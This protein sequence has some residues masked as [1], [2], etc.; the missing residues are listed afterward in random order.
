MYIPSAEAMR[1]A[2]TAAGLAG[3]GAAV[4]AGAGAGL[5]GAATGSSTHTEAAD[6]VSTGDPVCTKL[7]DDEMSTATHK[8]LAS[9][10]FIKNNP[11]IIFFRSLRSGKRYPAV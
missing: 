5:V 7:K 8:I 9:L 6:T 1:G 2:V 3:A 11:P 10:L 4:L